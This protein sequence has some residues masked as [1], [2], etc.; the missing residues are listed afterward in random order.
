MLNLIREAPPWWALWIYSDATQPSTVIHPY[1]LKL[2]FLQAVGSTMPSKPMMWCT[3]TDP[4]Q[5]KT[6]Y[7]L[8]PHNLT[9]CNTKLFL[10]WFQT[11]LRHSNHKLNLGSGDTWAQQSVQMIMYDR[12]QDSVLETLFQMCWFSWLVCHEVVQESPRMSSIVATASGSLAQGGVNENK[13][14]KRNHF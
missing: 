4:S 3:H 5:C 9:L 11:R 10:R 1:I 12:F 7:C 14:K 8:L 13:L 2:M 6:T